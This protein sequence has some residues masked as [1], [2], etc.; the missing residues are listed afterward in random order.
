L[1]TSPRNEPDGTLGRETTSDPVEPGFAASDDPSARRLQQLAHVT[2]LL[3]A[4]DSIDA[5]VDAVT[6]RVP[7]AIGAAVATLML[8][9]GDQLVLVGASGVQEGIEERFAA[10]GIADHNPASEAVRDGSPVILSADSDIEARYPVL[11]G[12][13][14]AGRSLVCLPLNEGKSRLGALGLTFE[15]GWTPGAIELDF[16]TTFADVCA[17]SVRRIRATLASEERA[18]YLSFL[19]DASIELASSLDYRQTLSRVA[20]LAVPAIADWCAVSILGDDELDTV[21]VAHIDPEKVAWAWELQA[22]YPTNIDDPTGA[23]AVVRSGVSEIHRQITDEH[24]IAGARDAEHLRLAREL[25][26]R[27]AMIVPLRARGRALGAITMLRTVSGRP[28]EATDLAVAEDLGRRAGVAIDN[29]RLHSLSEDVSRQLQRAVLPGQLQAIE[30][31][32]IATYYNAGGTA[33]VGGDFYDA[34][35]LEDGRMAVFIGDVM[36]HGLAAAASMAQMRAAIRAYVV[37]DPTPQVVV[38]K[39]DNMAARYA[40]NQLVTLVYGLVDLERG[41]FE[42]VNAGHYPPLLVSSDGT[43]HFAQTTPEPPIGTR[44]VTRTSSI[45]MLNHGDTVLLYTDGLVERRDEVI[46]VGLDRLLVAAHV[47]G[48]E[49]LGAG[50]AEMLAQLDDKTGD[51]D[52]TALAFRIA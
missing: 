24:L 13:V 9:D 35:A 3:A 52:V 18:F 17:Q 34:I 7:D 42:L 20:Q 2:A 43:T 25:D 5:V 8:V 50:L 10:W 21:A 6:N 46:D 23:P 14:P 32:E 12:T 40:M 16:L 31:C 26:V 47:M 1:P 29:A 28:Y 37:T 49:M 22:R 45:W 15:Q 39:L 11:A 51:D 41:E 38:T 30:G 48:S 19:S 36:G 33:E 4:A 27:S 44:D